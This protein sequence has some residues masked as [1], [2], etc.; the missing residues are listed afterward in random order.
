MGG[1][2]GKRHTQGQ[3]D[4]CTF[5]GTESKVTLPI[6]LV[7]LGLLSRFLIHSSFTLLSCTRYSPNLFT[8]TYF[9]NT[10]LHLFS[11][12]MSNTLLTYH[13]QLI[14]LPPTSPKSGSN[15]K[16]TYTFSYC[17]TYQTICVYTF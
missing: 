6:S 17:H 7:P 11:P 10:I 8:L 2:M 14:T 13:P 16:S 15:Q 1:F 9:E 5:C 12:E 3:N 4:S